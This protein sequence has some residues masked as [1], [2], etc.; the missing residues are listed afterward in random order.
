MIEIKN[1]KKF[2]TKQGLP[3]HLDG[4]RVFNALVEN[5]IENS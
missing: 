4:A 1:I 2:C 3:L 5:N